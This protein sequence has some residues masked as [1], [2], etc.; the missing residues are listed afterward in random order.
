LRPSQRKGFSFDV[1]KVV[2]GLAPLP[3]TTSFSGIKMNEETITEREKSI[4]GIEHE[5][6]EIKIV[7]KGVMEATMMLLA[8]K[9]MEMESWKKLAELRRWDEFLN[10]NDVSY[11]FVDDTSSNQAVS[12]SQN[13]IQ[14]NLIPNHSSPESRCKAKGFPRLL[15][16]NML[17]ATTTSKLEKMR[18]QEGKVR[19]LL[20]NMRAAVAK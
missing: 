20:R 4:Q 19:D 7:L 15:D 6:S 18:Q 12:G 14:D 17:S 2:K 13:R 8:R 5:L 1:R 9:Q 11:P 3:V 10:S 16:E